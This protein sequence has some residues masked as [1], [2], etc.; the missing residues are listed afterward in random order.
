MWDGYLDEKREA[1]NEALAKALGKD[2]IPLHTSGHCD[3]NDMRKL[4][5]M[6][7]PKGIIP[8]HTYRPDE[9]AKLFGNE[10]Y[11]I[12]LRDGEPFSPVKRL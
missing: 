1:Y 3:M 8:I 11:V 5:T 2:W 7:Q 4:F 10:W 9:F 12:K 6:L